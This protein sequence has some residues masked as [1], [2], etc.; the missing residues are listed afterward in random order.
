M[1]TCELHK[2]ENFCE[3]L[4]VNNACTVHHYESYEFVFFCSS[5]E[6]WQ[7]LAS[8]FYMSSTF[9]LLIMFIPYA[10]EKMIGKVFS[11]MEK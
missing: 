8:Y 10:E 4:I 2:N 1:L 6:V 9:P 5:L 3:F 11:I 7:I